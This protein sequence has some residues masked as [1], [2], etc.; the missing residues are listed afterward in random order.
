MADEKEINKQA[1][2]EFKDEKKKVKIRGPEF[3]LLC[4]LLVNFI[5]GAGA[6]GVITYIKFFTQKEKMKEAKEFSNIVEEDKKHALGPIYTLEEFKVN[7]ADPGGGTML[8]AR[9]ELEFFDEESLT[10]AEIVTSRIRHIII[11]ILTSKRRA[12]LLH[13]RGKLYLRDQI[14]RSINALLTKGSVKYVYF[15]KFVIQ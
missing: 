3:Y 4:I 7:L 1:Q 5:I 13:I 14:M 12:D 2:E 9:I 8:K 15:S 11:N 6:I 10:E